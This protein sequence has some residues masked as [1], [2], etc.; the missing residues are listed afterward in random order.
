MVDVL[1]EEWFQTLKQNLEKAVADSGIQLPDEEIVI[2]QV[3]TGYKDENLAYN[4]TMSSQGI[5]IDFGQPQHTSPTLLTDYSTYLE[6]L[7][8]Q[9]D[10][11]NA[12][13][14]SKIRAKGDFQ[15]LAAHKQLLQVIGNALSL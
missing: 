8:G 13:F 7:N 9:I 10:I 2:S 14:L 3:I 4:I 5:S 15:S 1:S 6:L 11:E 12:I